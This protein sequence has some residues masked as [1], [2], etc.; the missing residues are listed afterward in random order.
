MLVFK[1]IK[2]SLEKLLSSWDRYDSFLILGEEKIGKTTYL[3][4]L[5]KRICSSDRYVLKLDGYSEY[6][7]AYAPFQLSILNTGSKHTHVKQLGESILDGVTK[8]TRFPFKSLIN[9]V[10]NQS[11]VR[12]NSKLLTLNDIEKRIISQICM[13]ARNKQLIMMVD[14]Y[15]YWDERSCSLL[16]F[17][18]TKAAKNSLP[19]LS[20][21]KLVV[22]SISS[23]TSLNFDYTAKLRPST[24]YNTF[25]SQFE[26][27]APGYDD[28]FYKQLYSITGGNLGQ[29]KEISEFYALSKFNFSEPRIQNPTLTINVLQNVLKD[30]VVAIT[31][32]HSNFTPT[33]ESASVL[34][35]QF[36]AKF[37]QI[38][39][40]ISF[41]EIIENLSV[42]DQHKL[43]RKCTAMQNSY[44]F[45]DTLIHAFFYDMPDFRKHE[46]HRKFAHL[47]ESLQPF[48]YYKRY[49]HLYH[50]GLHER[51]Y[52]LFSI[53][54]LRQRQKKIPIATEHEQLLL[55][56]GGKYYESFSALDSALS[57]ADLPVAEVYLQ[58]IDASYGYLTLLERDYIY[59]MI[60]SQKGIS[61]EYDNVHR[62]LSEYFVDLRETYFE[63][64][65]RFGIF[66]LSFC[67]NR[68]CSHQQGKEVE[69]ILIFELS[70][71]C[72]E[73]LHWEI[74]AHILNRNSSALYSTEIALIKV[75]R[76]YDFFLSQSNECLEDYVFAAINYSGLLVVAS[77]YRK[78]YEYSKNCLYEMSEGNNFFYNIEKLLNNHI[79]SGY[80]AGELTVMD[81]I[82][83]FEKALES[84]EL[85]SKPLIANNYNLLIMYNGDIQKSLKFFLKH[86][87]CSRIKNHND[88]YRY[89]YR[90]NCVAALIATNQYDEA[91][92]I[93][94]TFHNL[95]PAIMKSEETALYKRYEVFNRIINERNTFGSVTEFEK[96]FRLYCGE[97]EFDYYSRPFIF[98]DQQVWSIV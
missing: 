34:G 38:F 67:V 94:K 58:S 64:W 77:E 45:Y 4:E 15:N 87:D 89:L 70:K 35:K 1:S 27:V 48:D 98:S 13:V 74:L 75:K 41:T 2:A 17:L 23:P 29:A 60:V 21:V 81:S 54:L 16:S 91:S 11:E 53:H 26:A 14:N 65:V 69:K 80:L 3:N 83:L 37:L 82:A 90:I 46:Y 66:L 39:D 71:R 59:A 40:D 79:V 18:M 50:A 10:I 86:Y 73:D 88:Y 55:K 43:I 19:F 6:Q 7:S 72:H 85:M 22:S 12:R 32:N 9:L 56:E 51:A 76:S 20:N 63:Q 31:K 30:R 93:Y 92:V 5:S 49:Y 62:M 68:I 97:N 42:A 36:E 84:K 47:F 28:L 78:A 33:M 57:A 61:S 25:I 44:E 95:I 52:E 8:D 24:A 96:Q